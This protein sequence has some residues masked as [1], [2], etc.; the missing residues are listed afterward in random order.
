MQVGELSQPVSELPGIGPGRTKELARLGIASVGDLLLHLPRGYEDRKTPRSLVEARPDAPVNTVAEVVAHSY[1]GG[2]GAKTLKVHIKDDTTIASLVCFGRNFLVRSLPVG[3]QIRVFGT[4]ANRYGELQASAFEFEDAERPPAKFGAVLPVYPLGGSLTQ[5]DLRRAM[6]GALDRYGRN[7]TP[8][9]PER[10]VTERK[11]LETHAALATVHRPENVNDALAARSTLIY[12]ELF[13]LQIAIGL[14]AYERRVRNRQ[15]RPLPRD[16]LERVR[17]RLPFELTGDQKKVLA[18]AMDDLES[19]IPMARLLQGDVGSGKTAIAFLT[20]LPLIESGYQVAFMAPTELLA[21]Q[22]ADNAARLLGEDIRIAFLS[23]SLPA[24]ARRALL[25]NIASGEVDLVIGTHAVFTPDVR[26]AALQYVIID[27]QHRFGVSQRLALSAKGAHP[28]LLTMT[29]TPIPRTLALTVFGDLQVST[30]R[31]LPG[32]RRPIETHLAR[33]GNEKK[34]YDFVRNELRAGRQAY[35]VYPRI[36]DTGALDL[37][38]AESMWR[39]L[40]DEVY[41]DVTVGLMHSRVPDDEKRERMESFRDGTTQVLVATSVVEVGVDVP[42]ATCM[43]VEH[44]ERFGLAALHQLRGRVGRGGHQSYC[45]LVYDENLT[46]VAKDRLKVLHE[47]TDGFVIA[48]EDLRIRGPGDVAGTQQ[49]GY[50]RLRIADLARDMETMNLAR[51]DAFDVL[52]SDPAL[53]LPEHAAI[54]RAV[55]AARTNG[56][57]TPFAP[58][59]EES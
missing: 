13:F 29:A 37:R 10:L 16:L 18:E 15:P 2:G 4:F 47:T 19:A 8:E 51:Q 34:V 30:I 54:R 42:N 20:A 39:Q 17:A 53:T 57:M 55:D 52:E 28:D 25:D 32:G 7:V 48:E 21:R 50:L 36:D 44:A 27:E 3:K 26:F 58:A 6:T 33:H 40:R 23:G 49:S 41:P 31:E 14:R 11:L 5:G 1:F 38:D 12:L 45:F 43:V 56:R 22:H 35:F 24:P 46:D 59:E 9:L